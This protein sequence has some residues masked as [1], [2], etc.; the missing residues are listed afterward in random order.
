MKKLNSTEDYKSLLDQDKPIILDFYADWCPPCKAQLPILEK[1]A[2]K[3]KGQVEVAK[4]NVDE[5]KELAQ[6]FR[7][8]NIPTIV[9]IKD[10]EIVHQKP[11]LHR[12]A[13]LERLVNQVTF[14]E[15]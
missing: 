10:G 6:Q 1:F 5:Q 15:A 2:E 14:V 7:V 13:E 9:L 8:R 11:G 12:A 4:I 3:Y